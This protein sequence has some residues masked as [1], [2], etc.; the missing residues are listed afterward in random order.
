MKNMTLYAVALAAVAGGVASTA[1]ANVVLATLRYDS[2]SGNYNAG[3]QTFNA[4]AADT[5]TLRTTGDTARLIGPTPGTASFAPGFV[6]GV[7]P[8]DFRLNVTAIP[9]ANPN[10]RTGAGTFVATDVDGD[11]ISGS[12]A[13]TWIRSSGF[14]FFNGA[15]SDVVITPAGAA[16]VNLSFDGNVGGW[17]LDLLAPQPYSGAIVQLVFN[18]PNFFSQDFTDRATGVTAQLIPTPG[19][20]ALAGLAGLIVGRRRAR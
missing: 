19:T 16:A 9:T 18:A 2:L 14:I 12:I 8:A 4:F 1:S 17:D 10:R 13:G 20:L 15:L 11:T 5:G 6:S 3:T 7:D